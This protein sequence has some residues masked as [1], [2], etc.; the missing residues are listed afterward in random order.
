MNASEPAFPV[1][2]NYYAGEDEDGKPIFDNFFGLT[3]RE[4]MATMM[5]QGI[6]AGG[7]DENDG[8]DHVSGVAVILADALLD[9]L[10]HDK[11]KPNNR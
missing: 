6:M 10:N 8:P 4:W 3:K 9:Q 7:I 2:G 1:H 11:E 5:A